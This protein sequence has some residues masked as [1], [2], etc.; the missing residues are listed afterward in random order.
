MIYL[1]FTHFATMCSSCYYESMQSKCIVRKA[2]DPTFSTG[3]YTPMAVEEWSKL[4]VIGQPN[5][6]YKFISSRATIQE[7]LS[8][9]DRKAWSVM[10]PYVLGIRRRNTSGAVLSPR[11]K[12][13]GTS[14]S[15][16]FS[17]CTVYNVKFFIYLTQDWSIY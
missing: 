14:I 16:L 13:F 7:Y 3:I 1:F 2:T 12:Y 6:F 4:H 17:I 5:A 9:G 10:P 11:R 15:K 8:H